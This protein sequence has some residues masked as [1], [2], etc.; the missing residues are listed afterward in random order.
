MTTRLVD[1]AGAGWVH[2]PVEVFEREQSIGILLDRT[3]QSD[4][5]TADVIAEALGDLPVAVVQASAMARRDRYSLAAYL[6]MLERTTLE[7]D[8]RRWEWD[9]YPRAAS[10]ALRLAFQSALK[11]IEDQGGPRK[12]AI[13]RVQLGILSMLAASGVP[14]RWLEKVDGI[15]IV[16]P[17]T[18]SGLIASSVCQLSEDRSK[19]MIHELQGRVIRE[20]WKGD[21]AIWRRVERQAS[22]LLGAVD[23]TA[24]PASDSASRRREALDLVEQLR[25]TAGQDYSRSLF[26]HFHFNTAY[27][28]AHALQYAAELGDPQAALSLSDAVNLLTRTLGPNH[29]HTLALRGNLANAYQTAGRLEQAISLYEQALADCERIL[30][31]DHPHTLT[32]RN[33]LATAY[34]AAGRLDEAVSLFER[35]LADTLRVLG[36]DHPDTL[37]LRGNLATAY[38]A[39][40]RLEQAISLYEQALAEALRVLGDNHPDTRLFRDNLVDAYRA[41]GRSEDTKTLAPLSASTADLLARTTLPGLNDDDALE[42]SR[43][44]EDPEYAELVAT[45]HR[46]L[47]AASDL[48][49]SL[50]TR[51]VADMTGR[52]PAAIARS[53]G[54]SLYAYHLGRNLRFPTWQFDG[55][56]P[57]PGL[58]TVVPALREGLTP[59]TVEAR[60]TSAD[61]EILDGLSPVEWLARGG[62]PTEATRVLTE[63]DHR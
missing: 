20:A 12:G 4:R 53:A 52:S 37:A 44:L 3:G 58:A 40:G 22:S 6:D 62:D 46:A 21:P 35:T 27:A 34:Q 31:P 55:G 60:M 29:P 50:S 48:A 13:A 47:V 36:P 57:L 61:P 1:W 7:E 25:A 32:S 17:K 24:I 33:N 5:E 49:R 18:L 2:V 11:W 26:S 51:E 43:I 14:T 39:A 56:R 23:V 59:M 38:Q 15:S 16:A 42:V 19:V 30:G 9:E 63:M 41:V 45:R 28:L 8:V 54:R 10:A